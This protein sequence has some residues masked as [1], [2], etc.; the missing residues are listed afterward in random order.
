MITSE[1]KPFAVHFDDLPQEGVLELRIGFDLMGAG[2]VSLDRIQ[3]YD[4]WFDQQDQ[5][6]LLQRVSAARHQLKQGNLLEPQQFLESYWPRLLLETQPL[7]PSNA[8]E[9]EGAS[10]TPRSARANRS[11]LDRM[12]TWVPTPTLPFR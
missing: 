1:W 12:K 7:Q 5:R 11:M 4:R 10:E 9:V 3:I 8:T 6:V 2:E